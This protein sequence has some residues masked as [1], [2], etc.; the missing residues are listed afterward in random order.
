[1]TE[2][3]S[4]YRQCP[5]GRAPE[6]HED[7]TKVELLKGVID[8]LFPG[9]PTVFVWSQPDEGQDVGVMANVPDEAG[10]VHLLGTA[11]TKLF[12]TSPDPSQLPVNVIPLTNPRN[13]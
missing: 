4:G 1:M 2:D 6:D 13:N 8:E 7:Y 5:C 9:T 12:M 10:A 11:I 3:H